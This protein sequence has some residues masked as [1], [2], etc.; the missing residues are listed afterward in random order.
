MLRALFYQYGV[1][2]DRFERICIEDFEPKDGK[3]LGPSGSPHH[4]RAEVIL[5]GPGRC[6]LFRAMVADDNFY[7]RFLDIHESK[8]MT[9]PSIAGQHISKLSMMRVEAA[10]QT[11]R[12]FG[13]VLA[14]ATHI[15][16]KQAREGGF[17]EGTPICLG[18]KPSYALP[19]FGPSAQSRLGQLGIMSYLRPSVIDER[20]FNANL[21]GAAVLAE[22]T[23]A[24]Q[25]RAATTKKSK[26]SVVA[27]S[28]K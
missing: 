6:R 11:D 18:G 14:Q 15:M 16:I 1:S 20:G 7:E 12:L 28:A 27:A 5:S 3:L 10:V 21:V 13:Q 24:H 4:I 23:Y 9:D 25:H 26:G 2:Y 19:F 17:E 22:K 8:Q